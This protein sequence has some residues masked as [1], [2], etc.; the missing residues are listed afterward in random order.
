[1]QARME[2]IWWATFRSKVNR[3]QQIRSSSCDFHSLYRSQRL[4]LRRNLKQ[5]L[6]RNP[7]RLRSQF[8]Q[9]KRTN[10]R[11]LHSRKHCSRYCSRSCKR[12]LRLRRKRCSRG[13]E[14][15]QNRLRLLLLLR[16]LKWKLLIGSTNNTSRSV[17]SRRKPKLNR[18][19][20]SKVD[21]LNRSRSRK[22]ECAREIGLLLISW[23]ERMPVFGVLP[24]EGD[25]AEVRQVREIARYA[26]R[27]WREN[28]A[29]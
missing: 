20:N 15:N 12:N 28:A 13:N 2:M 25:Y 22:R 8:N 21:T 26:V 14:R 9:R 17:L 1:M 7:F 29:R 24:S 16:M 27:F 10:S 6:H 3:S 19:L 5:R 23:R 18:R 11:K 4:H